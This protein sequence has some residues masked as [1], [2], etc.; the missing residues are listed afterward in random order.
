MATQV[1]NFKVIA[2]GTV[3][4]QTGGDIDIDLPFDLPDNTPP[5]PGY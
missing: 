2:S 5:A 3:R 4:V 1:S